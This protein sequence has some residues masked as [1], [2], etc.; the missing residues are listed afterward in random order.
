MSWRR[1]V[2]GCS[3]VKG[4]KCADVEMIFERLEATFGWV[5]G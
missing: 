4:V 1:G 5:T 3:V 2:E